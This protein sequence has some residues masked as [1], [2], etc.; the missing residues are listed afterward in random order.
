MIDSGLCLFLTGPPCAT[1]AYHREKLP[2][3]SLGGTGCGHSETP[4]Q[5]FPGLHYVLCRRTLHE[6]FLWFNIRKEHLDFLL[7][8]SRDGLWF[9]FLLC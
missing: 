8:D 7:L 3:S 1:P 6:K 4:G 5:V 2:E 9:S